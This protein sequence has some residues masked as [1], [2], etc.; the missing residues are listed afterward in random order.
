MSKSWKEERL[1]RFDNW[2]KDALDTFTN[3]GNQNHYLSEAECYEDIKSFISETIDEVL[4]A[5]RERIINELLAL[6]PEV[7]GNIGGRGVAINEIR[8]KIKSLKSP[9]K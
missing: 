1:E 7:K 5:E 8:N 9:T 4:R 6:I 3:G 2:A